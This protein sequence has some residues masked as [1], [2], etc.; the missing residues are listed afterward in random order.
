MG[1]PISHMSPAGPSQGG[2]HGGPPPGFGQPFSPPHGG[3]YIVY[4]RVR[5]VCAPSSRVS[6]ILLSACAVV[7][8]ITSPLQYT[9][10][11]RYNACAFEIA[12]RSLPAVSS[13]FGKSLTLINLSHTHQHL[14][15]HHTRTPIHKR[16][17]ANRVYPWADADAQRAGCEQRGAVRAV[18]HE[19]HAGWSCK[20]QHGV[21]DAVGRP[22]PSR[23]VAVLAGQC[24]DGRPG[25]TEPCKKR[26]EGATRV[27]TR[28]KKST[29][30]RL[31]AATR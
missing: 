30:Y 17:V 16:A 12:I 10:I 8:W 4:T 11:V 24:V 28:E 23:T 2:G 27:L 31:N 29:L 14:T 19:H 5:C 13:L 21:T 25:E 6:L 3:T 18:R 7:V 20:Q 22:C 9:Q 15:P 1:G 26:Q